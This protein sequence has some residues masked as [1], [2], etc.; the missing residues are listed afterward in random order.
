MSSTL[1][2]RRLKGIVT[3]RSMQGKVTKK[4]MLR[5]RKMQRKILKLRISAR[6]ML[7][8]HPKGSLPR[9]HRLVFSTLGLLRKQAGK[10]EGVILSL[11]FW[12]D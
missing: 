11:K 3:S 9:V 7:Q 10:V 12:A 4:R 5:T 8:R 6:K 1:M 2:R